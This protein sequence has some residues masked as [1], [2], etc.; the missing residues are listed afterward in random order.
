[1]KELIPVVNVIIVGWQDNCP[2]E[3]LLTGK[4]VI[5]YVNIIQ[6]LILYLGFEFVMKKMTMDGT[7]SALY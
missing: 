7:T 6:I 5:T 1:M 4:I 3:I 2:S